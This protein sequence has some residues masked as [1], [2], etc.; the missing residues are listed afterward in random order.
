[1]VPFAHGQWLAEHLPG[2][3]VHLLEGEGHWS[4]DIGGEQ[5]ILAHLLRLAGR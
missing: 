1:M 2:A 3:D 4:M 5:G